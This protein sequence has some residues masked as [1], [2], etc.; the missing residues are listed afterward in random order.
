M[1]PHPFQANPRSIGGRI[2]AIC[3]KSKT[4]NDHFEEGEIDSEEDFP[5]EATLPQGAEIAPDLSRIGGN[6]AREYAAQY[7]AQA[8][9]DE[10]N[11]SITSAGGYTTVQ[12]KVAGPVTSKLLLAASAF[13]QEAQP[14]EEA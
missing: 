1:S 11:F 2:C 13:M 9:L 12:I 6:P 7:Q 4:H 8:K 5:Q 10:S 3:G 14:K